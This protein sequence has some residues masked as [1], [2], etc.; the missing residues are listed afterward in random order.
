[1]PVKKKA[2]SVGK[3]ARVGKGKVPKDPFEDKSPLG[4]LKRKAAEDLGLI[5]KI[6]SLGWGGLSSAE[7]GRVGALVGRMRKQEETV[8]KDGHPGS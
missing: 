3:A 4:L 1:M 5:E 6:Y 8:R 7:S 2:A